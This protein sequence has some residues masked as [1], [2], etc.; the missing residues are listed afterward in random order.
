MFLFDD[1]A[2]FYTVLDQIHEGCAE[3]TPVGIIGSSFACS[4]PNEAQTREGGNIIGDAVYKLQQSR[5][6]RV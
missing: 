6:R 2:T 5:W 3:P 4:L 1:D